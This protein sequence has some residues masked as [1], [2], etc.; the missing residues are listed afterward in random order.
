MTGTISSNEK[1]S[2]MI[3]VEGRQVTL[4]FAREPDIQVAL[5]VKQALLGSCLSVGK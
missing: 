2:M 1:N 5:K 4:H 3:F